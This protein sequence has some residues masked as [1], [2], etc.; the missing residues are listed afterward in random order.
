M[1]RSLDGRVIELESRFFLSRFLRF[2]RRFRVREGVKAHFTGGLGGGCHE[3]ADGIEDDAELAI[4][5]PLDFLHLAGE[6]GIRGKHLAEADEGAHDGDVHL[7]GAR[8]PQN[9][10]QHGN[11]LLR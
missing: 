7:D 4:V 6:S 9:T 11:A 1:I 8:S 10:G 5:F 3:L 2:S